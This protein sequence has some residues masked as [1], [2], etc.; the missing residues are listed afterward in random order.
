MR[1]GNGD[2]LP[3]AH[4]LGQHFGSRND[5]DA[6]PAGFDDL[7]VVVADGRGLHEHVLVVD[8][9]REM[10]DVHV[11]AQALEMADR[12]RIG[13]VGAADL[14]A[15]VDEHFGDAAHARAA[16]ADHVYFFD[17]AVHAVLVTFSMRKN[18]D[19][20]LRFFKFFLWKHFCFNYL[21]KHTF[22]VFDF[23]AAE[24]E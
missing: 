11:G 14:I 21:V 22:L 17:P 16:D 6:A 5:R 13:D 12:R 3:E 24:G 19:L 23:L 4:E 18:L 2:A 10:A 8:V 9:F 20:F 7:G 1:A 15:E